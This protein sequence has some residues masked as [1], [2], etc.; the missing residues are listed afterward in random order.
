MTQRTGKSGD[1]EP[2]SILPQTSTNS[3]EQSSGSN[4]PWR[5]PTN[6]KQLAAQANNIATKVLN[7]GIDLETAKLY[8]SLARVVAHA[9]SLEVTRGRFLKEM[10]DLDLAEDE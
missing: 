5:Q 3:D 7:G 8:V 6:I 10:P 2:S 9:T 4:K 1:E